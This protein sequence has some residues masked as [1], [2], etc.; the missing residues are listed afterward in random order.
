MGQKK[1]NQIFEHR[2]YV[3]RSAQA[4][5]TVMPRLRPW[6]RSGQ[7]YHIPPEFYSQVVSQLQHLG[8]NV[9]TISDQIR[10]LPF[11]EWTRHNTPFRR[12]TIP[13]SPERWRYLSPVYRR[14]LRVP[15][16]GNMLI[17]RDGWTLQH[18]TANPVA[19]GPGSREYYFLED[20]KAIEG[21]RVLKGNESICKT[22]GGVTGRSIPSWVE[23]SILC[24]FWP[25]YYLP[26]EYDEVLMTRLPIGE[27]RVQTEFGGLVMWR[28]SD[29]P[30]IERILRPLR[31]ELRE[32][33]PEADWV[34]T[35]ALTLTRSYGQ[36]LQSQ[37][38]IEQFRD[39]VNRRSWSE[40]ADERLRLL[41][42]KLG[43]QADRDSCLARRILAYLTTRASWSLSSSDVGLDAIYG[44]ML[45]ADD[46]LWAGKATDVTYYRVGLPELG[47]VISWK[48]ELLEEWNNSQQQGGLIG[49]HWR[50]LPVLGRLRTNKGTK[51]EARDL[52]RRKRDMLWRALPGLPRVEW[53]LAE[54]GVFD[55]F[56]VDFDDKDWR[57][58]ND[59]MRYSCCCAKVIRRSP[60]EYDGPAL[61]M[62]DITGFRFV[63][64]TTELSR[65]FI[66][67]CGEWI[68]FLMRLS[69]HDLD[70]GLPNMGVFHLVSPRWLL[71][72]REDTVHNQTV[73]AAVK[74]LYN[75]TVT[76][77]REFLTNTPLVHV[78]E[79]ILDRLLTSGELVQ[80]GTL[81]YWHYPVLDDN[82]M[83]AYLARQKSPLATVLDRLRP[84]LHPLWVGYTNSLL[85]E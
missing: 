28:A 60:A 52:A 29:R 59:L 41:L 81:Y 77:L 7:E 66:P 8:L 1:K 82:G 65:E 61:L 6:M 69:A 78:L 85:M 56:T 57:G 44:I 55:A 49:G 15:S 2:R 36:Y 24:A 12:L 35:I 18:F 4:L 74:Y 70:L 47:L 37:H 45:E 71:L 51:P 75:P 20:R 43:E 42:T 72:A 14:W 23:G 25:G 33:N 27:E 50:L 38:G 32:W 79:S 22:Y 16:E 68:Y 13:D 46:V 31:L 64:E 80:D 76:E 39:L 19:G 40:V 10:Q 53:Q 11:I 67:P 48:T 58:H 21:C 9:T 5:E 30:L 3:L 73:A 62:E 83:K 63:L 34:K 26:P 84:T 17:V 54:Q